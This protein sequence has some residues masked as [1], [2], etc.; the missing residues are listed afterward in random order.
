MVKVNIPFVD[1]GQYKALL[2]TLEERSRG[3]LTAEEADSLIVESSGLERSLLEGSPKGRK[4]RTSNQSKDIENRIIDAYNEVYF[5]YRGRP[6][7]PEGASKHPKF[8]FNYFKKLLENKPEVV[9]IQPQENLLDSR[10]IY[11]IFNPYADFCGEGY[12][13]MNRHRR[14]QEIGRL[15]ITR[16]EECRFVE[17]DGW[18]ENALGYALGGHSDIQDLINQ[19]GQLRE[20]DARELNG[21]VKKAA[22]E[23]AKGMYGLN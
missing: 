12:D 9:T 6:D 17:G 10:R 19:F 23:K 1:L 2:R 14:D 11:G 3:T 18:V 21:P 7:F 20:L 4:R 15:V 5:G 8:V 13:V 16:I 22:I